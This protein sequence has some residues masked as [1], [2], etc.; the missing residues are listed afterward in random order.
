ME[1][2]AVG[3]GSRIR[4]DGYGKRERKEGPGKG[5][6]ATG[7]WGKEQAAQEAV[8]VGEG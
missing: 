2:A 5:I 8:A 7:P 6:D 4:S 1:D 3:W